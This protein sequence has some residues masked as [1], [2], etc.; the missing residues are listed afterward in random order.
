MSD[1]EAQCVRPIEKGEVD[2]EE[3]HVRPSLLPHSHRKQE[4]MIPLKGANAGILL[5]LH[6][7]PMISNTAITLLRGDDNSR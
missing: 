1:A 6:T 3:E 2:D 4:L 5:S 7:A